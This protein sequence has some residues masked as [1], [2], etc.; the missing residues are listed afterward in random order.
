MDRFFAVCAPGLGPFLAQELLRLSL[1]P[2]KPVL[3]SA[4]ESGLENA[5]N[6]PID[7]AQPRSAANL[8]LHLQAQVSPRNPMIADL[9]G[10]G[11]IEFQGDLRDLYC[12]N[13]WLRTASRIL[14][15][16]GEF[17]AAAFP[18][19]R[20][21]AASLPWE[22]Y[23]APGRAIALRVTCKKSRLYHSG[24]VAQRIA[25]AIADR[26][27]Q[28]PPVAKFDEDADADLPQLI[29]VRLATDSASRRPSQN[30]TRMPTPICRS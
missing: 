28:P 27:G 7:R 29:V 5:G 2:E 24:A 23:L 30:S 8:H 4:D 14:L 11:G 18:E 26:L 1:L 16:L 25:G 22:R 10:E 20:R 12:A 3:P 15:R 6:S 13:L 17:N 9:P 19:L 21:K